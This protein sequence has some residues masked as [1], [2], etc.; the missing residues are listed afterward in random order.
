MLVSLKLLPMVV[1]PPGV[2]DSK[3]DQKAEATVGFHSVE[4][5]GGCRRF[6]GCQASPALFQRYEGPV[7]SGSIFGVFNWARVEKVT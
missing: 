6:C 1:L 2:S 5:F 4:K 7:K 3:A